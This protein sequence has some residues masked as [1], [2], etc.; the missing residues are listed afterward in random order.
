MCR[1]MG[2]S[3]PGSEHKRYDS[4]PPI[5]NV[6]CIAQFYRLLGFTCRPARVVVVGAIVG[7]DR[8]DGL[9]DDTG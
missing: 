1:N 8:F 7:I 9:R 5:V 6:Q 4:F 2:L 3:P